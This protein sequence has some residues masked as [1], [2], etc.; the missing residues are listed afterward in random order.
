M[1]MKKILVI[2]DAQSLRRDIMEMLTYEQ[3]MVDGAENGMVGVERAKAYLP[4]LIICDIMM[5]A[6]DGYTVLEKLRDNPA[7]ATVPFIF[8]TARTDR[9]DVRQGMELGADD[10]LTKPFTATE[11][12]NTVKT[13]LHRQEVAK[14]IA[15]FKDKHLRQNLILALPHELRTPLNVILGFSDLLMLDYEVM[16]PGR[17]GDMARHINSAGM[18]LYRLIENFLVY[19]NI[20]IIDSSDEQRRDLRKASA[21]NPKLA[22]EY[23]AVQCARQHER[24][25]DLT[26]DITDIDCVQISEEYLKKIVEE[27]VDNAFKFSEDN[28]PV[29]VTAQRE[30]KLYVIRVSDE[31]RGMT[32]E[33]RSSIE[34]M[35]QFERP[36][37]EQQGIGLGLAIAYRLAEL[38]GGTLQIVSDYG[39]RTSV[40]VY[41][42]VCEV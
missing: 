38:H 25:V 6:M 8:L 16:E 29:R 37:Y 30:D 17:M 27:L 31:G 4:D 24:E 28:T 15:D 41:L 1:G 33:Q 9:V 2:E 19:A 18:R 7:T 23:A 21:Q 20:A 14:Q 12:L 32:P 39:E 13:R 35:V 40:T 34:A 26:T 36:F 3:F 10:Y 11:L 22:L 42:P 5:P